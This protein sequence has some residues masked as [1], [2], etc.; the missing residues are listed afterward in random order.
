MPQLRGKILIVDDEPRLA[1]VVKDMIGSDHETSVVT[2]GT[3]ALQLLMQEPDEARFDLIL[4]DLH[5]PE[6]SGMDLHEKLV[7]LRPAIAER[8]VFMTGGAFT[9]RSR[10]FVSRIGNACI[11]KPIDLGQLRNLVTTT[12]VRRQS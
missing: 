1:Q 8:M 3:D 6:I 4:C 10:D 7:A 12:L 2:T 11:D 5:M 9:E